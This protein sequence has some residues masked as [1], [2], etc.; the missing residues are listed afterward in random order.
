MQDLMTSEWRAKFENP[1]PSTPATAIT[2]ED[3]KPCYHVAPSGD[4]PGI[5]GTHGHFSTL[6]Y[7]VHARRFLQDAL[8]SSQRRPVVTV[9]RRHRP[10]AS[11]LHFHETAVSAT[12][13]HERHT[14]L[15]EPPL[16]VANTTNVA[17]KSAPRAAESSSYA[18]CATTRPRRTRWTVM[19]RRR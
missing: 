2:D 17:A 14:P 19:P 4:K 5:L 13:P 1:T 8:P 7:Y 3:R 10:R 18:V 15:I 9:A 6:R 16:Q 11:L 12:T